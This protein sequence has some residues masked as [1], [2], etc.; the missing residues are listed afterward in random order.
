M[1]QVLLVSDLHIGHKNIMGF[2]GQYRH[3]QTYIENIHEIVKMWNLVV[4]KR[5]KVF[6]LGDVCFKEEYMDVIDE[7]NGTKVLVR[8]N[9]DN[10]FSTREW[11]KY[12]D[13]VEGIV[14]YKGY[15]LTHAPIHPQE[16]RGKRNIHGHVHQ[17][18]I[19]NGYAECDERYINVCIENTGGAPIPFSR[20]KDGERGWLQWHEEGHPHIKVRD[21]LK[22]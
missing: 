1:G 21:Q 8:G 17:N 2:A 4:T 14:K 12:F 7:L 3:G 18:S 19:I 22:G 5:D 6:V 16:L 9:H 15:W 20:I 10:H 13:E 11:L